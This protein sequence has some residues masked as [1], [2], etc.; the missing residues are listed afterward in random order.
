MKNSNA[1]KYLCQNNIPQRNNI[2]SNHIWQPPALIPNMLQ[3][4][5][6]LYPLAYFLLAFFQWPF[7]KF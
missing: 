2:L 1:L 4:L 6:F 5:D 7:F 3:P